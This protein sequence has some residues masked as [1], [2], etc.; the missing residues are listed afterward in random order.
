[1]AKKE[2]AK[3][4][5]TKEIQVFVE[6]ESMGVADEVTSSDVQI[7]SLMLMQANAEIVKERSNDVQCG[8][9]VN[10]IDNEVWG[11]IDEPLRLCVYGMVKTELI[12]ETKNNKWI[13]TR[14]WEPSM[15][16]A[17]YKFQ[18][19]GVERKRQKV[20]NYICFRPL[21]VS[22]IT[23]NDGGKQYVALPIVVKFK[24]ASG[25]NA[26]KFNYLLDS[27]AKFKKPSFCMTFN[28]IAAEDKNEH[29]TFLVYNFNDMREAV[30][31][32]QMAGLMLA[33]VSKKAMAKNE[34]DVIDTEEV[35]VEKSVNNIRNHAP[36]ADGSPMPEQ[37]PS[38]LY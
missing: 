37:A 36:G 24:G 6:T 9:F 29:G 23:S 31:E 22:E 14:P 34:M 20:F 32:T 7:P 38:N 28:L 27:Y 10:S 30:K 21:D 18:V 2:L 35:T 19:D 4:E 16:N 33:Q 3:K 25:K 13:S 11:S 1:M 12:T 26:K 17:E 15:E 5:A 8:D